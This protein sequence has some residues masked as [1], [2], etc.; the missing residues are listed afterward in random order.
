MPVPD[1]RGKGAPKMRDK[2]RGE[3]NRSSTSRERQRAESK[4]PR[5]RPV[6]KRKPQPS[7]GSGEA[8]DE[9]AVLQQVLLLQEGQLENFHPVPLPSAVKRFLTRATPGQL[10]GTLVEVLAA[11]RSRRPQEDSLSRTHWIGA[12]KERSRPVRH[13]PR[14]LDNSSNA[15]VRRW[16]ARKGWREKVPSGAF[17]FQEHF[18]I[19][20]HSTP[21]T[22]SG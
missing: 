14:G 18:S 7:A 11:L 5:K 19:A 21:S 13:C 22:G 15:I 3:A 10:Q 12:T 20:R 2:P 1:F 9:I 8:R 4:G 16:T 17:S 6:P